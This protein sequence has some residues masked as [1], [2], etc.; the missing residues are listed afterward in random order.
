MPTTAWP[1]ERTWT[2][3]EIGLG[4][5]EGR[6]WRGS[7]RHPVHRRLRI[8]DLRAGDDSSSARCSSG[9]F[10]KPAISGGDRPRGAAAPSRSLRRSACRRMEWASCNSPRVSS[11][12]IHWPQRA[13]ANAAIELRIA[14]TCIGE[15][16]MR[17]GLNEADR[18]DR[19]HVAGRKSIETRSGS[20]QGSGQL[21]D[22]YPLSGWN[23]TPRRLA[24]RSMTGRARRCDT[25]PHRI[26]NWPRAV[27][28]RGSNQK[29]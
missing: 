10:V 27:G 29:G 28:S 6:G 17:G 22:Y 3:Q 23:R 25:E 12:I 18:H 11:S 7:S 15:R 24:G 20:H 4:H 21:A 9:M 1:P 13:Q 26:K 8:P 16:V 2:K 19:A 14:V 5:Y